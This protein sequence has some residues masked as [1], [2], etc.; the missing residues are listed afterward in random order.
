MKPNGNTEV[1][2]SRTRSLAAALS[3][4]KQRQLFRAAAA[5]AVGAWLLIQVAATITPMF[6]APAWLPRLVVL[7]AITGFVVTIGYFLL[8]YQPERG[9]LLGSRKGFWR[10]LAGGALL[11]ALATAG[12]WIA[13]RTSLLFGSETISLAVLPFADLSPGHDKAY[14][15]EGV[16]EEILSTL[17]AEKDIKVLGRTS[18]RQIER[19]PDPKAIRAALGIT[20][21]LEGSTRSDG[22]Q[23]RMNVRLI[24]T[25]DGSQLWEEEYR[26]KLADVFTVQ[27][28][29]AATVVK[30]LRRTFFDRALTEAPTTSVDAYQTYLA[31]RALMRDPKKEPLTQAWHMARQIVDA[32]PD[33]A[34]GQALY[35]SATFLLADDPYSY[36]DFPVD[37]ARRV[38][39]AHA[40]ESIRLAPDQA[41]GYAALGLASAPSDSLAPLQKAIALDRSRAS[42]RDNLGINL[43]LLGRH[44]E[45]FDQ[46]GLGVEIDPLSSALNN[47]YVASLATSGQADEAFRAIDTF[48]RRGGSEAQAWRFRGF[49]NTLIGNE[50]EAIAA[51]LRGLALDPALPYQPEWLAMEFNLLGLDDQEARY[52]AN[53]SRYLQLFL[54]DN[55]GALKTQVL[56]DGAKAWSANKF[57]FAIFSLA[58]ARD[59]PAI[60]RVY[61]V[62]PSGRKN[63]CAQL[64]NFAPFI[65][66]A[67]ERQGRAPESARILGCVQQSLTRQLAMRFRSPDEA[68]GEPE[69]WQASLLALRGDRRAFDWL[70]KAV[71]RGWLGQYYSPN[72]GDWPQFEGLRGEPR[73]AEIQRRIDARM[74]RERAETLKLFRLA[75][76][77]APA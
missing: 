24:D 38:A 58:R 56:G 18:A 13:G 47:R 5:Y 8:F 49:V 66:M 14:F 65:A 46:Y 64:P 10:L 7:L 44:D 40:R 27:D 54:A 62:R 52:R 26:G 28:K 76:P 41:D 51:R 39:I 20:H 75:V 4:L 42:L 43:N 68:P 72:L 71:A 9:S 30:R 12:T 35:A 74:A 16:A 23:L 70:D 61:N 60:V 34:P 19:N 45:A 63:L 22:D 59:W 32:H 55:R 31:A 77:R 69:L 73:Y 25:L 53:L 3:D 33:Y 15:A 67:L 2:V 36:G 29:I 57:E 48:V 21:I 6:D 1:E 17:A 37:K 11:A 50:S